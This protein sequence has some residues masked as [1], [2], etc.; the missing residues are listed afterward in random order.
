MNKFKGSKLAPAIV[1]IALGLALYAMPFLGENSRPMILLL[2]G[3]V[4]LV[5]YFA[6]RSY[7]LLVWGGILCGIGIGM[8][9]SVDDS[10]DPTRD[11]MQVGLGIGFL[12]IYFIRL[13][14]EKRSHWWPLIPGII[15]LLHGFSALRQVRIF[16]FNKNGWPLILVLIGVLM[17]F[18]SFGKSNKRDES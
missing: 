15:L 5:G 10:W 7:H 16:L 2:L 8:L 3:G 12:S 9:G 11:S 18:N 1:L 13:L 4:A 14:L 6:S 17:L